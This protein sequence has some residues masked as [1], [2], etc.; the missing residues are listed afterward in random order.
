MSVFK[1][2]LVYV[3]SLIVSDIICDLLNKFYAKKVNYNCDEC[4]NS[5]CYYKY[6]NKKRNELENKEDKK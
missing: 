3:F 4:K 6:C 2:F 1:C 5:D